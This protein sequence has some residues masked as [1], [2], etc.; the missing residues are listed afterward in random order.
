MQK[1]GLQTR[2]KR[3]LQS[4]EANDTVEAAV[5]FS[6]FGLKETIVGDKV[7]KSL[8]SKR[9]SSKLAH[10]VEALS[11]GPLGTD[12]RRRPGHSSHKRLQRQ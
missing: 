3:I 10:M 12:H 11:V 5:L 7:Y 2:V 1:T 8:E 4:I 9:A 6:A